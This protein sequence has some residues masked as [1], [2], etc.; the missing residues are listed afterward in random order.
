MAAAKDRAAAA[1]GIT[2][3]LSKINDPDPDIRFMQLNDLA[4]ILVA[5]ASIYVSGDTHT[6]A[7]IVEGLLKSLSDS[8]GEVQNQAL[9][10]Y[11]EGSLSK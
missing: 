11:D 2:T 3:L 10:W 9:K 6:A 5:P 7:R 4:N 1:Q 8:N